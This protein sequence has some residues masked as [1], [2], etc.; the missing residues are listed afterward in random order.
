MKKKLTITLLCL[1]LSWVIIPH[2]FAG[3]K[4]FKAGSESG[5]FGNLKWGADIATIDGM[6]YVG[7][8]DIGGSLPPDVSEVMDGKR[9]LRLY[10]RV[11]KVKYGDAKLL[12]W[13]YG[14]YHGRLAE[15]RL[16]SEGSEN[17]R[18]LKDKLFAEYGEGLHTVLP[19]HHGGHHSDP[20]LWDWEGKTTIMELTHSPSAGEAELWVASV[21]MRERIFQ[22]MK[23][24]GGKKDEKEAAQSPSHTC[25]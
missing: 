8:A 25:H 19:S 3:T 12:S 18:A 9:I 24:I 16:K 2:S 15:V 11:G 7:E 5:G 20:E 10:K 1:T 23:Q 17:W 6:E 22:Q 21:P 4:A 13:I 14:F